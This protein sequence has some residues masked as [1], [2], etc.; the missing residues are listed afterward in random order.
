MPLRVAAAVLAAS[1]ALPGGLAAQDAPEEGDPGVRP[2][3]RVTVAFYTASGDRPEEINGAR[4]VDRNGSIFLPFVGSV[5]VAGLGADEIRGRLED[6]YGPYFSEPVVTAQT[7]LRVNVT[8]S[9]IRPGHYF[10][11]PAMTVLDAL[12]QAGGTQA[13]VDARG[14]GVT[15]DPSN[16]KLTRDGVTLTLDL[17]P[18]HVTRRVM[19]MHIQSGDWIYVPPQPRSELRE[20][21]TFWG[22]VVSL[23][24]S[25]VALGYLITR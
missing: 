2:G 1:L 25:V 21:I 5:E 13:E 9:V 18:E 24:A 17:R 3:D 12:A 14:I 8:G 19:A 6:L 7:E 22:S 23:V 11:D 20:D 15:A 16:V 10:L 4:I